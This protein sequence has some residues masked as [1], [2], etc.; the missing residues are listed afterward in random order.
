MD[1]IERPRLVSDVMTRAVITLSEDDNLRGV[2]DGMKRFRFRHL[3]VVSGKKIVGL[4]THRQLLDVAVS[5][6]D[7]S[8]E[9]RTQALHDVLRARDVMVRKLVTARE[10]TPLIEAGRAM[11]NQKIGCL[12]VVSGDDDLVGILTEADFMLLAVRMLE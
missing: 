3:P 7:P 10:E 6:L 5:S 4:I 2:D 9:R 12:P 1:T 11:W 8:S